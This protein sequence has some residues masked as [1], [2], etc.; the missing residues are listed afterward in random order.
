MSPET[1]RILSLDPFSRD[2]ENLN[3]IDKEEMELGGYR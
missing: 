1:T 3:N 2:N